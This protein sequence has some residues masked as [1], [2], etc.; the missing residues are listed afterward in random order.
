MKIIFLGCTKFSEQ[1]LLC[2]LTHAF[3]IKAVFTIPKE[4][5]L[6]KK[7]QDESQHY[8]NS[9]YSDLGKIA[10]DY[11]IDC[12]NVDTKQGR[13]LISYSNIMKEIQPDV[14]LVLGW[15]Y[16]VP[17]IIREIAKVGTFGIHASLLPEYAGG[18][19]L[20]WAII[21]GEK[22]TGV[23]TFKLEEKVDT[24]NIYLQETIKIEREGEERNNRERNES[25]E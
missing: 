11:E 5:H 20:V 18:S 9:N 16:L 10:D 12:Y 14:I 13:N 17:K 21:N 25:F 8:N 3:N 19:P 2:L 1:M 7:G 24:G 15:Y 4:F 23:T 6:K 22:E